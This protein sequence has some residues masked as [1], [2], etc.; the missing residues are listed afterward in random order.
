[1]PAVTV[2]DVL[3]LPRVPRP[4]DSRERPVKSVTIA[5]SAFE[6]EDFPVRRAFA[7]LDQS[8][9]DPFIIMDQ[10]GEV[11]YRPGEAKGT[12]WHP[13]GGFETVTYIIDGTFQH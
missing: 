8:D 9:V 6:G 5:P 2:D 11:E 12:A 13:H 3:V 10:M 7:G 1:M 4:E